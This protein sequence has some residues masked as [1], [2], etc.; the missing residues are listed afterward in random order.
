MLLDSHLRTKTELQD[1]FEAFG[2]GAS[3]PQQ[4]R[5]LDAPRPANSSVVHAVQITAVARS[6]GFSRNLHGTIPA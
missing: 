1:R 5:G 2:P 4:L 6:T 3:E